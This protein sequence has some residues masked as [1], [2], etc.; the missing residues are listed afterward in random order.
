MFAPFGSKPA[1]HF[2]LAV[3]NDYFFFFF[4]AAFSAL[5]LR[6]MS[7]EWARLYV[8]MSTKRPL[9]SRTAYNFVPATL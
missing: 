1:K 5:L 4:A 9:A 3:V 7:M 8:W 6:F 2:L